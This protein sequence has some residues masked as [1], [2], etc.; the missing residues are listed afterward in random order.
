MTPEYWSRLQ[1]LFEAV[2]ALPEGDRQAYLEARCGDY[3]ALRDDVLGML[4]GERGKPLGEAELSD[5]AAQALADEQD[6]PYLG[7]SFGSYFFKSRIAVGGMSS[8][9][10]AEQT[11]YGGIVAIKVLRDPMG[12]ARR[13]LFDYEKRLLAQ[14][15]HPM[16]AQLFD[17]GT[18]DDG[19]AFFVMEYVDGLPITQYAQQ[20]RLPLTDRLALFRQVCEAVRYAHGRG[21][22]HRDLKPSNILVQDGGGVKLL[23]FGVSGQAG[24]AGGMAPS[25]SYMTL[26]YA[27]PEQIRHEPAEV[28][29][30]VYSLGVL[31][32]QLITGRLPFSLAGRTHDE[33]RAIV[34]TQAPSIPSE[35]VVENAVQIADSE[36]GAGD[37]RDPGIDAGALGRTDWT[38]LDHICGKALAKSTGTG[39]GDRYGSIES[40]VTDLDRFQQ[41]RPLKDFHPNR[42]YVPARF[43]QRNR[44]SVLLAAAA[45][46]C[47]VVLT[48]FHTYRLAKAR[49]AALAEAARTDRVEKFMEQLLTGGDPD[50]GP[51]LDLRVVT[52]LA[53]GVRD[54]KSLNTDPPIQ[55]T[56]YNLLGE[57]YGTMGDYK[58]AEPLFRSALDEQTHLYGSDSVQVAK[59]LASWATMREN[60]GQTGEAEEM[61][62]RALAID[63][64]KLPASNSQAIQA[65]VA[66]GLFLINRGAYTDAVHILENAVV[67]ASVKGA[68]PYDLSAAMSNLAD[69]EFYLGDLDKAAGLFERAL[70]IDRNLKGDENIDIAEDLMSLAAFEER[71]GRLAKAEQEERRALSIE[72]HWYENNDQPATAGAMTILAQTLVKEGHTPEALSLAEEA[73]AMRQRLHSPPSATFAHTWNA[74]GQIHWELGDLGG[75][76]KDHTEALNMYQQILPGQS[77]QAGLSLDNLSTIAFRR[78]QYSKADALSRDA[79]QMLTAKLPAGD[80]MIATAEVHYGQSLVAEHRLADAETQYL[81]AYAIL[82]QQKESHAADLMVLRGLLRALYQTGYKPEQATLYEH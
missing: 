66:L 67:Q 62:A 10:L 70:A 81:A 19:A 27:A 25:S 55:A 49:D 47:A 9:Y 15:R 18:L 32:Q 51:P 16:I 28:P 13:Q 11:D 82:M 26:A 40:V 42:W 21:V 54:A 38:D 75:A 52:V 56:L 53:Q 12:T 8:V 14:M 31:L 2:L 17:A 43:L 74:L 65:H 3:A 48:S 20:H 68:A 72:R 46:A 34:L 80:T 30:D 44:R 50:N 60:E 78:R 33:I 6:D 39:K 4:A 79:I 22:I 73:L 35:V 7:R 5:L 58:K 36:R 76:E 37:G 29:G 24:S 71:R 45:I 61:I 64:R 23:D 63:E 57:L 41:K 1:E 59:T 69:A 77:Y